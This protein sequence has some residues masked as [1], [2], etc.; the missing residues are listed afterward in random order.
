MNSVIFDEFVNVQ[1]GEAY[2]LFPF[3]KI[4]KNGKVREIT[5]EFAA[6]VRLPHFKPAI[7]LGSHEDVTPAGGHIKALEVRADGLY[8][9]PEY[10]DKGSQALLDGAYR[11]HSPEIIWEGG[12]ESPDGSVIS[13]PLIMGDALLHT[14]HLGEAA[15]LYSVEV[16]E[17]NKETNMQEKFEIPMTVWDKFTAFIDSRIHPAEPVKV[18]VIPED[19]TAAKQERDEYKAIIE[20]QKAEAAMKERVEKFTVDLN[21]IKVTPE[22][23]TILAGLADEAANAVMKQFKA[24]S[25]QINV[26]EIAK[27][28]GSPADGL[29]DDP[30][31]AFNAA[32]LSVSKEKGINYNAAFEHVKNSQPEMFKMAFA[33]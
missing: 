7:K 28:V 24:M 32:V 10:N 27:E 25:E 20:Q 1:A 26:S 13:A 5:P 23:A 19:Y 11:Y 4:V 16:I 6:T 3:G 15:S 14:P 18:E 12:L 22:L 2:R 21:E 30:K 29:V 31:A 8:A 33:K 9:I 17:S